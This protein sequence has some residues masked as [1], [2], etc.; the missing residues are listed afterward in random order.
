MQC[1]EVDILAATSRGTKSKAAG[2]S[3]V[4]AGPD[5]HVLRSS[6]DLARGTMMIKKS[7]RAMAPP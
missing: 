3:S 6:R 1:S 2:R 7:K 5:Q 4:D